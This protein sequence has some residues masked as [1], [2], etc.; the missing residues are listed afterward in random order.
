VQLKALAAALSRGLSPET[1]TDPLK[2]EVNFANDA[3]ES[4]LSEETS[5]SLKE[6]ES[7]VLKGANSIVGAQIMSGICRYEIR[8]SLRGQS[9]QT[10]FLSTLVA[11]T[12]LGKPSKECILPPVSVLLST[13]VRVVS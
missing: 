11:I 13:K 2:K 1:K 8:F 3:V 12:R 4:A 10:T 6:I 7:H 9:I 5:E